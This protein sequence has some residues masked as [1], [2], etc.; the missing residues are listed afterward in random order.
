MLATACQNIDVMELLLLR[1]SA[2]EST[3]EVSEWERIIL[4]YFHDA[5]TV[6]RYSKR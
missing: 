2:S 5:K 6:T 4:V 3:T 1:N